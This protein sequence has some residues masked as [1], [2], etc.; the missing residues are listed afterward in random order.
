M[1]FLLVPIVGLLAVS[2]AW[3]A[4]SVNLV[5]QPIEAELLLQSGGS[6][7]FPT[8]G[9]NFGDVPSRPYWGDFIYEGLSSVPIGA[10]LVLNSSQMVNS[11]PLAINLFYQDGGKETFEAGE[12]SLTIHGLPQNVG[13]LELT[14]GFAYLAGDALDLEEFPFALSRVVDG[15]GNVSLTLNNTGVW[16]R[17]EGAGAIKLTGVFTAVPEPSILSV[18]LFSGA[19]CCGLRRRRN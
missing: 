16:N 2:P 5:G 12:F 10:S 9:Y 13:G 6:N 11:S 1:K 4:L 17:P 8:M 15:E 14:A 19:V 7:L 3:G 18:V